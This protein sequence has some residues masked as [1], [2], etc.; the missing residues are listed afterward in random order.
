MAKSADAADLKSVGLKWLW[1][2][3]SPSGHHRINELPLYCNLICAGLVGD[4]VG[5]R[6]SSIRSATSFRN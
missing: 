1:E 2:F 6:I 4:L 3:K 5:D